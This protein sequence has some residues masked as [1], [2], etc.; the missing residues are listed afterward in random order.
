V[1]LA[2]SDEQQ[3][4]RDAVEKYLAG[5]VPATHTRRFIEGEGY[6]TALWRSMATEPGLPGIAV[7]EALGGSGAG[8]VEAA[9]MFEVAGQ[10]L[11]CSPLFG[12]AGLAVPALLDAAE[13][14]ARN[15]LLSRIASGDTTAT[16]AFPSTGQATS[17]TATGG[18]DARV[19]GVVDRVV[20]GAT[21]DVLIV[22]AVTDDGPTLLA[23]DCAADG[24]SATSLESLDPT[25]PLASVALDSAA[26][27]LLAVGD[28]VAPALRHAQ[29]VSSMLLAAEQLGGLQASLD[30]AVAHARIRVQFGRPIGAFQAVKHLCA[31]MFVDLET[32]RWTVYV[33]AWT[34]GADIAEGREGAEYL[35]AMTRAVVSESFTRSTANLLQVLGGIGYTWE[36]DAHLLFKRAVSSARLLG[37]VDEALDVVAGRIGLGT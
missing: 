14:S 29:A 24:V 17:L 32:S 8:L 2:L 7:P 26:G 4:F 31:D 5:R 6:D 34:L 20:D 15:E 30:V 28:M 11:L 33:T 37:T 19:T 1:L 36:H 3:Q 16:A 9:L 27:T 13:G 18:A 25:R 12:T 23:V 10:A 35:A 22:L 21:A